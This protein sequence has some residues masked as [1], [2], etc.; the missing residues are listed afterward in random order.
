ML[1]LKTIS[2]YEPEMK[3]LG[4]SEVARSQRGYLTAL[5]RAGSYKN[6]SDK[7][8]QRQ[9]GFV[10]RHYAQYKKHPTYRRRLSLIAWSFDP[11]SRR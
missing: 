10:A 2:K 7:W 3:R 5:K 11:E 4:V 1:S 6:L 8:K 9:R